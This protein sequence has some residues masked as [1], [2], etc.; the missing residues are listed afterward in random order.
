MRTPKILL[1]GKNGQDGFELQRS[2][3][4][5]GDVIAIDIEDCDLTDTEAIVALVEIANRAGFDTKCMPRDIKPISTE[6]YPLPAPRPKN[7]KMGLD[8]LKEAYGI[9]VPHW[10]IEVEFVVTQ[11]FNNQT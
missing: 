1:T 9:E 3:T 11:L 2:L 4:P 8:K 10:S 5:Q 7:S 6:A